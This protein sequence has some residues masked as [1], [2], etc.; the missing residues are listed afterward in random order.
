LSETTPAV[1]S[2][3]AEPITIKPSRLP[4]I[5]WLRGFFI[6]LMVIYHFCYDLDLFGYIDTAFGRGAWIPFRYVIVIGFLTLVGISLVIVHHKGIN[7]Q[8]VKKRS[9]Q[10]AIACLFVSGSGY[11][12][13]PHKITIF[14]I[15]QFILVASFL[16]LPFINKPKLALVLGIAVFAIGHSVTFPLFNSIW[17]HWIGMGETLR[18]ALDFLPLVP[19]IGVVLVGIYCG[20]WFI[21]ETGNKVGS[22]TLSEHKNKLVSKLSRFIETMGQHSL[23]IYLVH[24]PILFGIFYALEYVN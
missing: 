13:A 21:S 12:I 3:A 1:Q 17:L 23:I 2:I 5:D 20:H 15:L 22:F 18:P 10:L 14:G 24:Q 6:L 4:F 9:F 16:V 11:F 8:S 7:W 19:W